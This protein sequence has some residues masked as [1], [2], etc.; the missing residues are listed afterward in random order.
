MQTMGTVS[1]AAIYNVQSCVF[2]FVIAVVMAVSVLAMHENVHQ[3][4]SQQHEVRQHT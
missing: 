4:A 2:L 1:A 3:R